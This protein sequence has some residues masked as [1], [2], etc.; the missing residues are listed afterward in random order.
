MDKAELLLKN[1]QNGIECSFFTVLHQH[2]VILL[3]GFTT[4]PAACS[5][6]L[7]AK[8]YLTSPHSQCEHRIIP[9][10]AKYGPK[11]TGISCNLYG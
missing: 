8:N 10:C 7:G 4:K 1:E 3:C 11:Q 6:A 2:V 5:V 9:F